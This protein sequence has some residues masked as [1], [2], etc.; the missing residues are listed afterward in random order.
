MQ[1][2]EMN[3]FSSAVSVLLDELADLPCAGCVRGKLI[4]LFT[5]VDTPTLLA[6]SVVARRQDSSECDGSHDIREDVVLTA[7]E[8]FSLG[9]ESVRLDLVGLLRRSSF[10]EVRQELAKAEAGKDVQRVLE[11]VLDSAEMGVPIRSLRARV[12]AL[13]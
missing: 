1:G 12:T 3:G 10:P 7:L 11:S 9:L 13:E 2:K 5:S 6:L 8:R 4:G